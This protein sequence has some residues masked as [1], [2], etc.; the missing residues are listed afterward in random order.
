MMTI[1]C[2]LC[3]EAGGTIIYQNEFIRII[4]ANEEHYPGFTRV[5]LNQHIAE[6][7]DLND[8]HREKLMKYVYLVETVQREV[9]KP[10][11]INLAQFGTMV[12]HLH[13]HIIP[14]FEWDLHFPNSFWGTVTKDGNNPTYQQFLQQQVQL[15]DTYHNTLKKYAQQFV[16]V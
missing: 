7:T 12:P 13:W 8:E 4:N 16:F 11:K 5:I 15:L 10:H 1:S 2:I 9:L 6:M 14:R 3:Q